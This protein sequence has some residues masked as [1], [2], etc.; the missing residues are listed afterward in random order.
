MQHIFIYEIAQVLQEEWR[1]CS[2]DISG[3]EVLQSSYNLE[4]YHIFFPSSYLH[5]HRVFISI[6]A[7]EEEG[8]DLSTV[9]ARN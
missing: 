8:R 4:T 3:W 1:T 5:S 9:I 2:R 6:G 7:K